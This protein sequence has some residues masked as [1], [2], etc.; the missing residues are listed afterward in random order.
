VKNKKRIFAED[1]LVA[2][3]SGQLLNERDCLNRPAVVFVR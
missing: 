1:S 2:R 3:T